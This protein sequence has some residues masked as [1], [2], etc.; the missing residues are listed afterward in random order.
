MRNLIAATAAVL[1]IAA[2]VA[3]LPLLVFGL[4]FLALAAVATVS[5]TTGFQ[6]GRS[7]LLDRPERVA[8]G[9]AAILL[10]GGLAAASRDELF[11]TEVL[12]ASEDLK[13]FTVLQDHQLAV[14][15]RRGVG[16]IGT[17]ASPEDVIGKAVVVAV[18]KGEMLEP[19]DVRAVELLAQRT[20]VTVEIATG[21]SI[22]PEGS[23]ATL[24]ASPTV[25]GFRSAIIDDV[26]VIAVGST[27]NDDAV[28]LAV[29]ADEL[30]DV[31]ALL[32]VAEFRLLVSG[33]TG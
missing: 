13:Q 16:G 1:G 28:T 5:L 6:A 20:L 15:Q 10:I 31:V 14:E 25:R 8:A 24:A 27:G 18:T 19:S 22:P 33:P 12:V 11:A 32:A 17:I 4:L 23:T 21:S 30:H 9:V 29:P 26:H 7:Q 3:T 2:V